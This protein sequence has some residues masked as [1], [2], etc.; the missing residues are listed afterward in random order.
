M[1]KLSV[2]VKYPIVLCSVCLVCGAALAGVN[3]VT[4]PKISQ[5]EYEVAHAAMTKLVSKAGLTTSGDAYVLE[6]NEGVEHEYLNERD[7]VPCT[8]GTYYYYNATS[9]TGYSGT[10]TFGALVD[11]N[12]EVIGFSYLSATED[13]TGISAAKGINI[14]VD[15]PYTT[16]TVT[17]G[18]SAGKTLPAISKALQAI[19]A[20]AKT[21]TK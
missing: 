7:V 5:H 13:T 12:Y 20:D 4:A 15:S 6:W 16:G 10:V 8:Q 3:Y 1:K 17:S 21:I 18:A 14:G 11:P 2:Y 9:P 19:I